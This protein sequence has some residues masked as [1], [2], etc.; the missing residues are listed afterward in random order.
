MFFL[1]QKGFFD[2]NSQML[3][4]NPFHWKVL[5]PKLPYISQRKHLGYDIME[6]TQPYR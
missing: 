3:E 2:P 6:Y 5:F 1:D 4:G